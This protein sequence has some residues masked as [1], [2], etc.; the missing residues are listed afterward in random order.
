[1]AIGVVC[2]FQAEVDCFWNAVNQAGLDHEVFRIIASGSSAKRG[3]DAA[4]ELIRQ[5][6]DKLL[7]FGIAGGLTP[8]LRVG[9][10]VFSNHVVTPLDESYGKRPASKKV[11]GLAMGAS[12]PLLMSVCG[13][14]DIIFQPTEKAKLHQLTRAAIADMESHGVARAANAAGIPF[15]VLRSVSDA[16]S[17]H[18]PEFVANGVNEDGTPNLKPILMALLKNPFRLGALLKLKGNTDTALA[19]LQKAAFTELPK[20]I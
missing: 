9:D 20:L 19:A 17:D 8:K 2:G 13:V 7:S 6:C 10:V 4:D 16:V 15:F 5:G 3:R 1:M 14:D 11:E 12:K 18:L